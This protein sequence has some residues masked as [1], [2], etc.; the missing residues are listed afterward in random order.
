MPQF[1]ILLLI[2]LLHSTLKVWALDTVLGHD[3][4]QHVASVIPANI[5]PTRCNNIRFIYICKPLYMFRPV[6]P[7]SLDASCHCKLSWTWP[8]ASCSHDHYSL[9]S[10]FLLMPDAVDTVIWAPDHGSIYTIRNTYSG[11]EIYIKCILLHF[12]GQV[13]A[14]ILRYTDHLR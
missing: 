14:C 13:L 1:H 8:D 7:P 3:I 10:R 5:C 2:L 12:V 4:C 6:S 11:L 9:Q